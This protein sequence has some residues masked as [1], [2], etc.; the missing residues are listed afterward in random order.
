LQKGNKFQ[1]FQFF[2]YHSLGV[3]TKKNAPALF[4][5][6]SF[7]QPLI[8]PQRIDSI[9]QKYKYD[10]IFDIFLTFPRNSSYVS[11][12]VDNSCL[13]WSARYQEK[14][15]PVDH[16]F[17]SPFCLDESHPLINPHSNFRGPFSIR[18]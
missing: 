6:A 1:P 14:L 16:Q 11:A 2:Q 15:T 12:V 17:V 4:T 7:A 3:H 9:W 10:Y 18:R 8:L 13:D 5:G